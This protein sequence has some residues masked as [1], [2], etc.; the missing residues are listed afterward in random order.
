MP[1]CWCCPQGRGCQARGWC[2]LALLRYQGTGCTWTKMW[3]PWLRSRCRWGR[4]CRSMNQRSQSTFRPCSPCSLP[5]VQ[6]QCYRETCRPDSPAGGQRMCRSGVRAQQAKGNNRHHRH[7]M[8]T[9]AATRA[10]RAHHRASDR[11]G[12]PRGG[13]A[14]VASIASACGDGVAGVSGSGVISG[15]RCT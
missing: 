14:I 9:Y 8:S 4:A 7:A 2:F 3:H 13:G 6:H 15:A 11:G 5:A 1:T 10:T 12:A